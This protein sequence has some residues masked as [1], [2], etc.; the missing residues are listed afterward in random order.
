MSITLVWLLIGHGYFAGVM[1]TRLVSTFTSESACLQAVEYSTANYGGDVKFSC[2]MQTVQGYVQPQS[3][4][5]YGARV[6]GEM[7]GR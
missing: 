2:Q 7:L 1:D 5:T 6:A 3:G 4:W